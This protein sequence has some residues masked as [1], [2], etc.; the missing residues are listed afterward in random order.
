MCLDNNLKTLYQKA[1]GTCTLRNTSHFGKYVMYISNFPSICLN[2]NLPFKSLLPRE[3]GDI[4]MAF[5]YKK[6]KKAIVMNYKNTLYELMLRQHF[7]SWCHF[8]IL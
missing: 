3:T 2:F 7:D 6:N 8:H 4:V 1:E 5:C